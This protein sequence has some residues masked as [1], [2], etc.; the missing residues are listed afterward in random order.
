[1]NNWSTPSAHDGRRPGPDGTST[2]GRNLKREAEGFVADAEHTIGGGNLV[3]SPNHTCGIDPEGAAELWPTPR[4]TD[5]AAG[6][7]AIQS[8]I[9]FYRPSKEFDAGRKVG[10][11][12]LSDVS[13]QWATPSAHE[14]THD[15]REVGHGIQLANQAVEELWMTPNTVNTTSHKAK[16]E[17]P[18][19]GPQR[20]G[21]SIGLEEQAAELWQTPKAMDTGT[22]RE[23][24]K[25]LKNDRQT[26]DPNFIGNYK[27][28][29]MDQA[30]LWQTPQVDSFRSRGGDRKD[31]MG[32]DQQAR[33]QW[34]TPASRDWKGANSETHVTETGGGQKAHGPVEQ[35]GRALFPPGPAD[36]E[37]WAAIIQER[38]DLA[39]AV[40]SEVRRVADGDAR[41]LGEFA[42][43][44]QLRGLGNA[45]VPQ[46]AALALLLLIEQAA[47]NT[48]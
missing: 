28:D 45:V 27:L 22:P 11:A 18:T 29:L 23:L 37:Q 41:R 5:E 3:S 25:R 38:S 16:Y 12:N 31:E 33:L 2:Q 1:M 19:S 9:T 21:P 4:T 47:E 24:S 6:R 13:E 7:G 8:G 20:G 44:D 35:P 30:G 46:C 48:K 39:P 36:R 40:E 17:R 14:R 26:R 42:R 43:A 34:V 10:Q 15:P 32:L